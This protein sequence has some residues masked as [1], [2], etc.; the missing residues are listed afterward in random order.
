M[1][2]T[3]GRS[4]FS[5]SASQA[6]SDDSVE[7]R[8]TTSGACAANDARFVSLLINDASAGTNSTFE[9]TIKPSI[10]SRTRERTAAP[11]SIAIT[12]TPQANASHITLPKPS[13][14]EAEAKISAL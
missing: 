5:S 8:V 14:H 13:T 6:L 12:G 2:R 4:T 7:N 9:G 11:H 3:Y 10:P 1:N